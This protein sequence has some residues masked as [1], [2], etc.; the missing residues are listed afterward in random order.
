MQPSVGRI[1]HFQTRGSADGVY[2]PTCFAAFVTEV[3]G[4]VVGLATFGP[5][6]LR[7]ERAVEHDESHAHGTWHWPERV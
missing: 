3:D 6:G 5:S 4:D 2:P 1:V 7:F